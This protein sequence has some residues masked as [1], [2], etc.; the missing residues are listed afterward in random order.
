MMSR[1]CVV[2][3]NASE[4]SSTH[5]T[6]IPSR[7]VITAADILLG[8]DVDLGAEPAADFR[9]NRTNLILPEAGHRRDE[10]AEDV[11]VLR[12]R[13]DGHRTLARLEVR[14]HA[15]PF[16]RVRHQTMVDHSLRDHD[17]GL[18]KRLVDG[19][20]V[21]FSSRIHA[22]AAL[23]ERHRQ[24]V[25]ELG[26]NDRGLPLHGELG[27]DHGR[28]YLVVDDDG[29]GCVARDIPIAGHD[30]RD[31]LAAVAD[32]VHGDC[33]VR[34]R[35]ER[36]PDRH[37]REHLGNLGAGEHRLDAFHRLRGADVDAADATM[38]HVAALERQMLHPGDL[39]V[40]HVRAATLNETRILAALD[41]LP[42][43]LRQNWRRGHAHLLS[44]AY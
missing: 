15:A 26:V 20:V 14:H 30:H 40:V 43:E 8:V 41:A 21:P 12:G 35:R 22:R 13:P 39:D 2:A 27:I 7:F 31:R 24:V 28:Q 38:R 37:R 10:R 11:R 1:P 16:H 25:R 4:R 42:Y 44:A 23:N 19:R 36:R 29:I 17:L 32:R 34:R 6:G 9:R 18:G 33:T 3:T 5:L